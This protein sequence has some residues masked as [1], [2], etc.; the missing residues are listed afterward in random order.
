[1]ETRDVAFPQGAEILGPHLYYDSRY[2][3]RNRA[4]SRTHNFV[5]RIAYQ[6]CFP[7]IQ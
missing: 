6:I 2:I 4:S 1:M 3:Y 5:L 7:T